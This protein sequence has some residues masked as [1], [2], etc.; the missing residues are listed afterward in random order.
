M[1][2]S[3][4]VQCYQHSFSE[5]VLTVLASML[6]CSEAERRELDLLPR[7]IEPAANLRD[8][9]VRFLESG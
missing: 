6:D 8:S 9:W 7:E 3:L 1:V 2:S 5:E 4:L